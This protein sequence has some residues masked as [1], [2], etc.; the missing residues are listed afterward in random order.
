M[1]IAVAGGSGLVGRYVVDVARSRGHEVA[2]LSRSNGVDLR[3]GGG[4]QAA[5]DGADAIIDVTNPSASDRPAA[6]AFF[7]EIAAR[8]QTAGAEAHVQR[9]ITLSI[10]GIEAA[11]DNS[12]YSAKLRQEQATLDGPVPAT[13]MRATQFHEFAV[14]TLRRNTHGS[15]ARVPNLRVQPVAARSVAQCLVDLADNAQPLPSRAPDLAGPAQLQLADM[16]RAFVEHFDL[17][18]SVEPVPGDPSVPDGAVLPRTADA[19][20]EGPSF[21]KWL[22]SDDAA[23]L[24]H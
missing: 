12:Y 24:A 5:L 6:A 9:I 20:L 13:V 17:H 11:P 16:A 23:R 15:V 18:I 2:V 8:L 19:R 3:F 7:T 1:R 10:V 14:Q 21:E 4:L 22:E